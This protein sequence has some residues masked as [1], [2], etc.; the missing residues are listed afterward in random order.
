MANINVRAATPNVAF[1]RPELVAAIPEYDVIRDA[2]GGSTRI[3]AAKTKYLPRPNPGDVSAPN[4][5]RYDA[6][7]KRAVFYG[8]TGRTLRGLSGQ[9]FMRDPVIEVPETMQAVVD[10]TNGEGVS[11]TQL[12]KKVTNLVI[13]YGRSGL[14]VDYPKTDGLVTKL[15]LEEGGIRPTITGFEPWS[16]INWRTR[17]RGAVSVLNMVVLEESYIQSDDGFE[18][19]LDTQWRVLKLSDADQY[20]V[21]IWRKAAAR[22]FTLF[23]SYTP[24]DANGKPFSDIPF[25]FVGAENNDSEVDA[26]PLFDLADIN[27][28]H[29]RNSADHEENL[30]VSAQATPVLTGLNESW[31]D[32][33]FKE[34]VG[35][36]S[37]A[38]IP[39][40][41][42][43]D[44]KLI[45]AEER[46]A[47]FTEM[48]HK[49]RQ[50]VALGAKLVEQK[51][52]Q[53]TA[54]EAG[55]EEAGE[56]SVLSNIAN[57]VSLA[58]VWALGWAAMFVGVPETGIVFEA[59]SDFDISKMSPG[60]RAQLIAEWQAEAITWTEMRAGLRK[61][62]V[63]TLPDDE[64]E[65]EIREAI[66]LPTQTGGDRGP[67]T[68]EQ[69]AEADALAAAEAAKLKTKPPVK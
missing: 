32:K 24:L 20:R 30:Y 56:S 42:G 35:L 2:I 44:A 65:A 39:L 18:V 61:S 36:G 19:K 69:Q 23:D 37:R 64:A 9:V 60:E 34:G 45:Q 40:P 31:A 7:L 66:P 48:E 53:R 54:T 13:P 26:P 51:Q 27:V 62:G 68:P 25:C 57:N 41:V 10:D 1:K 63:A 14:F 29:Y 3:K 5:A 38:A 46:G 4:N 55:L 8:V 16:I 33:Y 47:I 6:Y 11:L 50:M 67:L 22:N 43:G 21:E 58:F 52:V 17:K 28:A 12:A 49:E 15:Q 59:N